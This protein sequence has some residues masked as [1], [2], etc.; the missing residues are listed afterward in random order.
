V[1]TSGVSPIPVADG[2]YNLDI[3]T[4]PVT[5]AQVT[6]EAGEAVQVEV[7]VPGN[8]EIVDD[9]GQPNPVYLYVYALDGTLITGG[10]SPVQVAAGDYTV[11]LATV[12]PTS[13]EFTI[14]AGE[15]TALTSPR[16]GQIEIV[17]AGGQPSDAYSYVYDA[18]TD[19]LVSGGITPIIVLAGTYRIELAT[20]PTVTIED[21]IVT[22]GETTT[23]SLPG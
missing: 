5:T 23:V 2:V 14:T 15:T 17:T 6:V 1:V 19:A 4:V 18:D 10:V 12:P 8:L 3:S 20:E 21:V 9:L 16:P 7:G 13:F 11:D 22:T